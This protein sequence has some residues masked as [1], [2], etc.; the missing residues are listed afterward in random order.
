MLKFMSTISPRSE[1]PIEAYVSIRKRKMLS[2]FL[3]YAKRMD[4]PDVATLKSNDKAKTQNVKRY[5]QT[6]HF[7]YFH[8]VP[9]SGAPIPRSKVLKSHN[10]RQTQNHLP[11]GRSR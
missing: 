4:A 8:P 9:S 3:Q 5:L 6:L 7:V 11:P 1:K 2:K 10:I